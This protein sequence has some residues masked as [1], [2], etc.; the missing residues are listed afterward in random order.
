MQNA[1]CVFALGT[2]GANDMRIFERV[3][4]LRSDPFG[5]DVRQVPQV[6]DQRLNRP[7]LILI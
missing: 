6:M 2:D 4:F 5:G 1:Y 7:L 3:N